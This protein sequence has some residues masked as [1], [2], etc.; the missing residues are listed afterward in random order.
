MLDGDDDRDQQDP[1]TP[2]LPSRLRRQPS[3]TDDLQ[4]RP[5]CEEGFKTKPTYLANFDWSKLFWNPLNGS[6]TMNILAW[7]TPGGAKGVAQLWVIGKIEYATLV[8]NQFSSYMIKL[9]LTSDDRQNL[10]LMLKKWGNL[11]KDWNP[12]SIKSVVNF[13][14]RPD[15][16]QELIELISDDEEAL[17]VVRTIYFQDTFPFTY[18]VRESADVNSDFPDPGYDVDD[19]KAGATVA[20]EFQILSR[21]FKASKKVD[22][23]KA[24]SFRLLGV[25]LVDDPMHSTMLTPNKRQRGEDEW[26][27]TPPRTRKTITSKNPLET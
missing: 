16:V 18:D 10:R 2:S 1:V 9:C 17:D 19:F 13:S 8:V 3:W 6:E 20:V 26:M 24:Y 22:A 25:Y 15:K 4:P 14:T 5:K 7:K 21:N 12:A 27:V 23:V 11:G